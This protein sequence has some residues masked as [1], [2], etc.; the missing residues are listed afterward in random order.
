MSLA[1]YYVGLMSGTS[2]DAVDAVIVDFSGDKLA[3]IASYSTPLSQN[4][5]LKIHALATPSHNEIDRLGELDQELGELF[6][7]SINE[8][9]KNNNLPCKSIMAIGSHGQTIRHRPPGSV[10]HPFTIQI[11]DPNIIAQRTGITTVADFRR[12]DMAAGGHGAP[13]VPAF[14]RALFYKADMDRVIINIGGM[15]NITWLP[16]TGDAIGFDTGPGN[17]LMD[18]WMLQNQNKAYDTNGDW[19]ASG[20][21]HQE[22]LQQLL[23]HSFFRQPPPKS[24]GRETF[25]SH[26]LEAEIARLKI[27]PKAN[28]IQ[29][30]L[31]LLTATS[32]ADCINT[33]TQ[34]STEVFVCG[35]GAYN[36][37]LMNELKLQ[38]PKSKIASTAAL[39]IAPE[40]V[41]AIAFAWLAKQTMNRQNGNLRAVTGAREE[42]ILGGVYFA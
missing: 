1:N 33:L 6:A 31:L 28:D 37:R 30:T 19:A 7:T 29:A 8:L 14:H 13:L 18:A 3:L 39:G 17:V 4:L 25:N 23:Q 2:A 27:T 21:A 11:G 10:Q 38:L 26:W 32:I 40:W 15:A 20:Q 41:E 35:G 12:R 22:L 42:V 24:T 5:R 34:S 36:L 16:T 9:I